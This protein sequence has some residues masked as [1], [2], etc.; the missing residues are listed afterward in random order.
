LTG[1][2]ISEGISFIES[3]DDK[4]PSWAIH[5]VR[6][7]VFIYEATEI[8]ACLFQAFAFR[9]VPAMF[10]IKIFFVLLAPLHKLGKTVILTKTRKDR[11]F[12]FSASAVTSL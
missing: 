10:R 1:R 8:F 5:R 7:T 4:R 2:V 3:E 9:N 12:T 11:K 6:K